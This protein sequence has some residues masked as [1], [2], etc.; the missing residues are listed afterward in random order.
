MSMITVGIGDLGVGRAPVTR[1]V[2]THA[3]GS[4]IGVFAWDPETKIG[5]CLHYLLP[6]SDDP[7]SPLKF[8]DTGLPRLVTGVA[9]T[10]AA[11]LRL[12]IVACGG[13]TL[14]G[15]GGMFR[16]GERNIAAMKNYFWTLGLVLAGQDVGGN[17]ARTARLD[18]DS[19]LVTVDSG[20]RSL[21]L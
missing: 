1:G 9:P 3:L 21:T 6:R 7:N 18:L 5:G 14:N 4:C 15:D 2:V 10:K 13:A 16:I 17:Q 19:G 20:G 12:R 8:A 11:A